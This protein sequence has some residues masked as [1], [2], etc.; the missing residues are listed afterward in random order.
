MV[1]LI[2]REHPAPDLARLVSARVRSALYHSPARWANCKAPGHCFDFGA[3]RESGRS[4]A[5][6]S[7]TRIWTGPRPC[8]DETDARFRRSEQR[9]R[10]LVRQHQASNAPDA[11]GP[12]PSGPRRRVREC[13]RTPAKGIPT[14]TYTPSAPADL[15]ETGTCP[16]IPF[17]LQSHHRACAGHCCRS[18]ASH[19]NSRKWGEYQGATK[20]QGRLYRRS[21]REPFAGDA[22]RHLLE[23]GAA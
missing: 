8:S 13:A 20:S 17:R 19:Q 23:P 6:R 4:V 14:E 22:G 5:A 18:P 15:G 2:C 10:A 7:A 9:L 16:T 1:S 11:G 21:Q 3:N 12:G